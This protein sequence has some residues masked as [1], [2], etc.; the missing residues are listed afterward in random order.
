MSG[1]LEQ[2]DTLSPEDVMKVSARSVPGSLAGHHQLVSWLIQQGGFIH[3]DIV[4]AYQLG[5]G[6]HAVLGP[7]K[8]IA[9]NTRIASCPMETTLCVLNPLDIAPF[10]CRGTRFPQKFLD[11][12]CLMP[13]VLQT[14]FL[15]EQYLQGEKSWWS[16]YIATLPSLEDIKDLQFES[17]EDRRWI[18]GTNLEGA[19]DLQL[20]N[21]HEN[22]AGGLN[23]L[24]ECGWPNAQDGRLSW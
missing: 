19:L 9:K 11:T 23:I 12:Y 13:E 7:G 6:Y 3:P 4:I 2:F 8:S 5:K 22:F 1:L 15:M 10:S 18:H 16:Q 21:W 14:F 20:H 24:K 17:P